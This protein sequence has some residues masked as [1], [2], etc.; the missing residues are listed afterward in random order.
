MCS[1]DDFTKI[2]YQDENKIK[3]TFKIRFLQIAGKIECDPFSTNPSDQAKIKSELN[4]AETMQKISR[5]KDI[6][7]YCEKRYGEIIAS[8]ISHLIESYNS[9]GQPSCLIDQYISLLYL[10]FIESE[11]NK[12]TTNL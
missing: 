12:K 8:H 2:F 6:K 10:L 11:P 9:D 3:K 1:K 5:K 4:K 7:T